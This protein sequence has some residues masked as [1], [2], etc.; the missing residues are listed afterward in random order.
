VVRQGKLAQEAGKTLEMIGDDVGVIGL[1]GL[2]ERAIENLIENAL[3]YAPEGTTVSV[4]LWRESDA[5]GVDVLDEG[6]GISPSEAGRIFDRFARGDEG[7]DRKAGGTGLGLA[8]V[9]S[10]MKAMGGSVELVTAEPGNT[11]FRLRFL[12]T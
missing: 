5:A 4:R 10:A 2:A 12:L 9:A 3:R 1:E 6:P 11:C 8:I 7:R